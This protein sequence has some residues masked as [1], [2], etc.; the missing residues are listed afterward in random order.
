MVDYV[1]KECNNNNTMTH[2]KRNVTT[3]THQWNANNRQTT[4]DTSLQ[5][6]FL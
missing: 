1:A 6:T 4:T 5:K 2:C 3:E